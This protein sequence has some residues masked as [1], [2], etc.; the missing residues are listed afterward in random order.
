M[1]ESYGAGVVEACD[2]ASIVAAIEE[3]RQRRHA[4]ALQ[5]ATQFRVGKQPVDSK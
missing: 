5:R 1:A 2:P 3:L 4:L